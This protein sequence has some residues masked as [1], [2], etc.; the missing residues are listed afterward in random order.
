MEAGNRS[1]SSRCSFDPTDPADD[2]SEPTIDAS[3]KAVAAAVSAPFGPA[4]T[5]AAS[6]DPAVGQ[7]EADAIGSTVNTTGAELERWST[8]AP[9]G[10]GLPFAAK[11]NP[12]DPAAA[13]AAALTAPVSPTQAVA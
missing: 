8:P 6:D 2:E 5:V 9:A 4:G 11:G 1:G 13:D 12:E 10:T 7:P 3:G